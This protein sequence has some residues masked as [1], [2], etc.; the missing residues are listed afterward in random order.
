MESLQRGLAEKGGRERDGCLK[1]SSGSLTEVLSNVRTIYQKR[2]NGREG[3][4]E[5]EIAGFCMQERKLA[6]W[7]CV[8]MMGRKCLFL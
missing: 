5:H 2:E 1:C 3:R 4:M 6:L 8:V 7:I